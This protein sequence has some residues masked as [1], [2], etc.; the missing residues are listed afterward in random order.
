MDMSICKNSYSLLSSSRFSLARSLAL[1]SLYA[2]GFYV[3]SFLR[4]GL[5]TFKDFYVQG[6]F[7]SGVL[8]FIDS[9]VHEFLRSGVPR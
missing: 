7:R 5:L 8:T 6:F 1:L 3:H 2:Q 9:Y 4:S